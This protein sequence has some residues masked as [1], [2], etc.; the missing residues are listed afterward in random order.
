VINGSRHEKNKMTIEGGKNL[1]A[2]WGSEDWKN[3]LNRE[4]GRKNIRKD[5]V[6]A[7]EILSITQTGCSS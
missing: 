1:I 4:F 3:P 5:Q 7:E 2:K 6:L